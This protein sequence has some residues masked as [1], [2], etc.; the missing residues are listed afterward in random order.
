MF[1]P[2]LRAAS[3]AGIV[4]GLLL[5]LV[6]AASIAPLLRDAEAVE[7]AVAGPHDAAHDAAP[8]ANSVPRLASTGVANVVLATGFALMLA[9]AMALRG[10]RG[11]RAGVAFGV[12]GYWVF[13]VAPSIGVPPTLPGIDVAPLGEHTTWWV[14]TA[15]CS[16]AGLALAAFGRG[17]PL[18]VLGLALLVV[19]FMIGAPQ[20]ATA[21]PRAASELAGTFSRNAY[22][23]NALSWLVLGAIVGATRVGPRTRA[24]D[25]TP[26]SGAP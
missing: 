25:V 8:P 14:S 7:H 22:L 10:A 23:A 26:P 1:V 15:A 6:Q 9:G 18:R 13:F 3:L 4:A 19:P 2:L 11:W 17:A 12:A 20:P 21:D 24:Q 5:T 16:A